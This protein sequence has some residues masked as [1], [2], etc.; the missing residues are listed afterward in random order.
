MGIVIPFPHRINPDGTIDSICPLCYVTVGTSSHVA[1]LERME[2]A[3]F[4]EGGRLRYYEARREWAEATAA[5]R[6]ITRGRVDQ[7]RKIGGGRFT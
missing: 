2:A 3:H 1:D 5:R 7:G 6:V 4:C